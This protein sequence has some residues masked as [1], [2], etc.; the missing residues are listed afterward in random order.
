MP[1]FKK[2]KNPRLPS[3]FRPVAILCSLSK[4]LESLVLAQ[5]APFLRQCLPSEQWGFR[6]ARSTSGALA[7]AHGHWTRSRSRGEAVAVAAFD[8][9]CAFDTLGVQELVSKLEGLG[10]GKK[11]VLWF[12]NYLSDRCQR[13]RYRSACSSLK[14]IS[15]GV[16]QGSLLGPVLFTA[17]VSD[18]P[19]VLRGKE[20]DGVGVTMYADDLCIWSAHRDPLTAKTRLER[21]S[22]LLLS[23]ALA[24]SLSIN[25]GK[26]QLLWAGA[27]PPIPIHVG[28]TLV[29]PGNELLLL[30]VLFDSRLTITPHLKAMGGAARS[31]LALTRRLLLHLPRVR[32]VQDIVRSLVVGKLCYGSILFSPRLSQ[33]DPTCQLIQSL[34]TSVNDIARLRLGVSRAD[35]VPVAQLLEDT[36]MPVINHIVIRTILC[37][38]WKCLRSS[39]GPSHG[40]NPLGALMSLPPSTRPTRSTSA[41]D[42]VLPL[43]VKA[44]TFIWHAAKLYNEVPSL[45]SARSLAAARRI[46]EDY[47]RA[48]PI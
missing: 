6:R 2:G 8:F 41:G 9:S 29:R 14:N 24:N 30:G 20:D 4:V 35:C 25:A 28:E 23:Y 36:K 45:R 34:Q 39:D 33:T 27:A 17:L 15:Y 21:A 12:Q 37:E 10:I 18:L 32:Q 26:T 11:A 48:A 7:S 5:F 42:L 19:G 22:G 13:G 38:S 47:S 3:S 44:N 31:L 40:M 43:R 46:A 16:P 1:V